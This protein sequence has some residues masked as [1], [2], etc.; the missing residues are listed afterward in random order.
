MAKRDDKLA[1]AVIEGKRQ[2]GTADESTAAQADLN[3][4]GRPQDTL[5]PRAKN[6]GKGKKTADKWNQ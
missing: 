5:D 6:S 2:R 3:E 4:P 1:E